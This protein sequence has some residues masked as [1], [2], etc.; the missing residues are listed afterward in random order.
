VNPFCICS[1]DESLAAEITETPQGTYTV[2][3]I[4]AEARREAGESAGDFVLDSLYGLDIDL[5]VRHANA[6]VTQTPVVLP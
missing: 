5:A 6:W 3:L 1:G 4:D 2:R